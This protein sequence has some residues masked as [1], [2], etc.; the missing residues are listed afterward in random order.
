MRLPAQIVVGI[1]VV[2]TIGVAYWFAS[3]GVPPARERPAWLV[4]MPIAHRGLFS[5]SGGAPENSLAA[6]RRA[7]DKGLTIELDVRATRDGEV[8]VMHDDTLGRMTGD[9][10]RISDVTAAEIA[11]LRLKGSDESIPT[12]AEVLRLVDG[13]VPLFIEIKNRGSVG[14]L[15]EALAKELDGYEG[16]VAAI[17]FNPYSLAYLAKRSP[18]VVRGQLSGTFKGEGVAW[19]K[20]IVLQRLLL[21]WKSRPSFI[22]YETVAL[23]RL[24][25]TL[26][27]M[28]GRYLI[29]WVAKDAEQLTRTRELCDGVIVEGAAIE[30][31]SKPW[32]LEGDATP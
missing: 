25:T 5:P 6:F 15:E 2:A 13:Q 27:R 29:G 28:R 31:M 17:S 19:Y 9:P 26:Q 24:D 30:G 7:M 16:R 10:R 8:V 20:E 1:A 14:R 12:L 23:P 4:A 22:V 32:T 3:G 11:K 21:N 18:R